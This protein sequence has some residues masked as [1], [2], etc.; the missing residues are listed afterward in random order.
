M[1]ESG[2]LCINESLV[3]RNAC[4]LPSPTLCPSEVMS[5][6][7]DRREPVALV[8][9]LRPH[10]R[11]GRASPRKALLLLHAL[12][13][14]AAGKERLE[15]FADIVRPLSI[16]IRRFGWSP[17]GTPKP[18][19][20]FTALRTDN[21]SDH[22]IGRTVPWMLAVSLRPVLASGAASVQ[23]PGKEFV[24]HVLVTDRSQEAAD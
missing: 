5:A 14:I 8:G 4:N 12:G 7:L 15:R 24:G 17:A 16:P 9:S 21:L 6:D 23:F 18:H 22:L 1:T 3:H 10:R 2:P 20:P 11:P 19:C 13:R